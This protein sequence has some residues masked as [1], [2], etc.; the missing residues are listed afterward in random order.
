MRADRNLHED[1]VALSPERAS[2]QASTCDRH[3]APDQ[4]QDDAVGSEGDRNIGEDHADHEQQAPRRLCDCEWSCSRSARAR[5]GRWRA[6]RARWL[7]RGRPR[8]RG[9]KTRRRGRRRVRSALAARPTKAP[10]CLSAERCVG[11]HRPLGRASQ[12][13]RGPTPPGP[14][15]GHGEPSGPTAPRR[16]AQSPGQASATAAAGPSRSRRPH[17]RRGSQSSEGRSGHRRK[18]ATAALRSGPGQ[19]SRARPSELRVRSRALR[20]AATQ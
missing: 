13:S 5:C 6:P 1:V 7:R 17:Q 8:R 12:T 20:R 14:P 3:R 2:A 16:S 18:P 4:R 11:R 9:A 19:R 15:A 10:A